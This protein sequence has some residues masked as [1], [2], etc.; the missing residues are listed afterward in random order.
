MKASV[1][2]ILLTPTV[3]KIYALSV[4]SWYLR[5]YKELRMSVDPA[6]THILWGFAPHGV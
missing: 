5:T 3:I 4:I 6:D 2:S 1:S